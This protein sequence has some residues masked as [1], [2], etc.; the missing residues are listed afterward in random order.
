M[1]RVEITD[2]AANGCIPVCIL[3]NCQVV[4]TNHYPDSIQNVGE[5]FRILHSEPLLYNRESPLPLPLCFLS[6]I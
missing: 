3:D 4:L 6:A 2:S 1:V 5:A